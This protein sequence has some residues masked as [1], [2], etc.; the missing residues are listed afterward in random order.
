MLPPKVT[1]VQF[2]FFTTQSVGFNRNCNQILA[3]HFPRITVI[4]VIA[5]CCQLPSISL[6][7]RMRIKVWIT[8]Y[9]VLVF[10][11]AIR[12][13]VVSFRVCETEPLS[14]PLFVCRYVNS[15]FLWTFVC[16]NFFLDFLFW[17]QFSFFVF[18][19]KSISEKRQL[20][21]RKVS[22]SVALLICSFTHGI[23]R[24]VLWILF[25]S[26]TAIPTVTY[27]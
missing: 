1:Y 14:H 6:F 8:N 7:G 2:G 27:L 17:Q 26:S 20:L 12:Y 21:K 9:A 18:T 5:P 22:R 4:R 23:L 3:R 16:N 15:N 25:L 24:Y 13:V 19:A 11:F 10:F